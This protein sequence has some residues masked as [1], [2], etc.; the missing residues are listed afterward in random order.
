MESMSKFFR[1]ENGAALAE[2]GVL[3]ALVAIVCVGAI[4]LLGGNVS[5]FLFLKAAAMFP[6]A[7]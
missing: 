5:K 6:P 2:Y 1:E 7:P 4:T 3:I